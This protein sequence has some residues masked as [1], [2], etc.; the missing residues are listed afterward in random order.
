MRGLFLLSILSD[1]MLPDSNGYSIYNMF[2]KDEKMNKIPFIFQSGLVSQE[3][4]LRK[5][6]I[7]KAVEIIYKPYKQSDL[8]AVISKVLGK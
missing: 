4:E 5:N 6:L 8:L 2:S 7:D 3:L 1:I